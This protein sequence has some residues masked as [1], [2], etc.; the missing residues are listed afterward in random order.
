MQ[1]RGY[2]SMKRK[3]DKKGMPSTRKRGQ[4][5]ARG[6]VFALMLVL[7]VFVSTVALGEISLTKRD[8]AMNGGLDKSVSNILVLM[9]DGEKTSAAMIASINSRTGRSVMTRVD[10]ALTV[11]VP[12]VGSVAL[13]DVYMLGDARSR[14]LVAMRAINQLLGL[15]VSTYVA[16]DIANLPKLVDAV[17][18]LNME[19]DEAEAAAMGTWSGINELS[20]EQALAYVRLRLEGDS[21]ARSRGYDALMQLLYQGMHSGDLMSMIG[22]GR[23][24]LSSMDTN[25][26]PMTAVTL[27]TAVQG[28][29]DRRELLLPQSEH[30][31]AQEPLTADAQAMREA[32]HKEVYE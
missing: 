24:L 18:A 8:I 30:V 7:L 11:D 32:L 14:G 1:E 10:C 16:L 19:L 26:N 23:K 31:T 12:E 17:G 15:N 3:P 29:D 21:P 27:V 6:V 2:E 5:H 25:L 9:Q 4:G 28:G 20:G 13:G 22:L